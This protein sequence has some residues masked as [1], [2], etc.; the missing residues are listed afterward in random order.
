MSLGMSTS[1]LFFFFLKKTLTATTHFALI[2]LLNYQILH[3]HMTEVSILN[4]FAA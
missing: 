2:A 1:F 4:L 3:L